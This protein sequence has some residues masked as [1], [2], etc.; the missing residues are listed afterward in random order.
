MARPKDDA[1]TARRISDAVYAVLARGGPQ[2]L[3]VRAVAREAGC[4]TG[5][6]MHTFS[7]KRSML[8]NARRLEQE[9]AAFLL[10]RVDDA[11]SDVATLLRETLLVLVAPG[12]PA[13]GSRPGQGADDDARVRLGFL[14]AALDDDVLRAEQRSAH[15]ELVARVRAL[16]ERR[17]PDLSR[18]D[19]AATTLALVSLV[20][21]L[22]ALST[23]DPE[24]YTPEAREA[25]VDRALAAHGLSTPAGGTAAGTAEAETTRRGASATV[26][27]W[28]PV[29]DARAVGDLLRGYHRQ[30]EREKGAEPGDPLPDAYRAEVEHPAA[31]LATSE[32]LVA[33]DAAD[34]AIGLVV[35][36]HAG[37]V[38]SVSRLW[39]DPDR[40]GLGAGRRLLD[41]ARERA[42]DGGAEALELTVWEWRTGPIDLYTRCGFERVGREP[43]RPRLVRM[44][45]A[46]APR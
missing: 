43:D 38:P 9:R 25:A 16:V 30:T 34:R 20:E 32:V 40:R 27:L 46:L 41:A 15:R 33:R 22:S 4:S 1:A 18:H 12:R 5:L 29:R 2:S 11:G 42:A 26:T 21:G 24:L 10:A 17:R 44:R 35:L 23:A 36:R 6:L 14:A 45:A 28:D 39:V 19:V 8:L 3:T 31:A 13:A 37:E 7:D